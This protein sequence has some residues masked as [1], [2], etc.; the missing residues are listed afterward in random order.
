MDF[1]ALH[2]ALFSI[3]AICADGLAIYFTIEGDPKKFGGAIRSATSRPPK[4]IQENNESKNTQYAYINI[5]SYFLLN[6]NFFLGQATEVERQG[7]CP[8]SLDKHRE[9]IR[10]KYGN[11]IKTA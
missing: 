11:D 6:A 1:S 9:K 2:C 3:S 7:P 4:Q 10:G 8:V 5:I